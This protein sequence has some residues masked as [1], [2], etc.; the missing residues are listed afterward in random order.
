MA[1][2]NF[3]NLELPE[4]KETSKTNQWQ[5][6]IPKRIV[7]RVESLGGNREVALTLIESAVVASL[8]NYMHR[9]EKERKNGSG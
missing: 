4:E 7:E 5:F 1:P 8:G 9:L 6:T 3:D 2:L